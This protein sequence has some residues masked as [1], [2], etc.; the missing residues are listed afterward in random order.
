MK[1]YD[2][3]SL[4]WEEVRPGVRRK[5]F[6]SANALLV[7]NELQ[8]GM[9]ARPHSH[10]FEQLVYILKGRVRFTV[11][12]EVHELEP[13]GLCVIPPDATH[14]ADV[15]G[16]EPALNLDIFSPVREDYLH[17]TEAQTEYQRSD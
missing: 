10:P 11:G 2:W 14:F 1:T 17:L 16:D 9:E 15:L 12:D 13:G 3:E 6:R 7:L 5:G 8:P 4:A